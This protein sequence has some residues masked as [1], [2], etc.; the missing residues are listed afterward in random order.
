MP[1]K[2]VRIATAIIAANFLVWKVILPLGGLAL[3]AIHPKSIGESPLLS[4]MAG[5]VYFVFLVPALVLF[6]V[7]FYK[8]RQGRN[9]ARIVFA[10]VVAL[11]MISAFGDV[12]LFSMLNAGHWSIV[13]IA[14]LLLFGLAY[15]AANITA[16]VLL[17]SSTGNAWF[18]D[19]HK[20]A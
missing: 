20:E 4:V 13:G 11:T 18:V 10:A 2:S 15:P 12:R 3:N 9:W 16:A 14:S 6:A 1:P 17:F 5:T 19:E 8:L 7:L